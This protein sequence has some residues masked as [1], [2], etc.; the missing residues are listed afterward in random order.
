MKKRDLGFGSLGNGLS[1]YDR[2]HEKHGDY[3]KVAHISPTRE[4][5]YCA[6][7]APEYKDAIEHEARTADPNISH[8]QEGK[9]FLTRPE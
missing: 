1:V 7:L 5:T 2:L 8:T 6:T 9:V 4:V 3:E